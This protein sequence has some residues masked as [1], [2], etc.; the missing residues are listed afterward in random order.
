MIEDVAKFQLHLSVSFVPL[1]FVTW[2]RNYRTKRVPCLTD[3][4]KL[5]T[6]KLETIDFTTSPYR[7]YFL[8]P[9][10]NRAIFFSQPCNSL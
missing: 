9:V 3:A 6:G 7:F 1:L 2:Y 5:D 8:F 4:Y 10:S